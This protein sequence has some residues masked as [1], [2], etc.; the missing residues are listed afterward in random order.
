MNPR[1]A[2]LAVLVAALPAA[3]IRADDY[4]PAHDVRDV[5]W[6]AARLLART[7]RASGA[8][9]KAVQ[10][11]DVVVARDQALL[12][13]DS[14]K[15]HG[16]MT[17]VRSSDRWWDALDMLAPQAPGNCWAG[18][19]S[20]PLDDG[21]VQMRP[22][23]DLL[24]EHGVSPGLA[25]AAAAHNRDVRDAD[26]QVAACR[27]SMAQN[28]PDESIPPRGA[29]IRPLRAR[30]SG[31]D[32]T[33]AFSRNDASSAVQL[34]QMYA[35]APTRAEFVPNPAPAPGWGGPDAAC[36]FDISIGSTAP[37]TFSPGTTVDVWFPFVIDDQ[38]R[39]NLTFFS[40]GKPSGFI[41]GTVFDNT[42]HFAL[43]QFTLAPGK[44][45][46]AEIDGDAKRAR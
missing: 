42:L 3:P 46:M 26:S 4:G 31:Y 24:H 32:F 38:L 28:D 39:Y 21:L 36:F 41:F 11:S 22:A 30:T 37:V 45:L 20:Y 19:M 9:P 13:W 16:V 40:G 15:Q 27:V 7:V 14:G 25:A 17:L 1:I 12:S 18:S 23:T 35:R 43:P 8:D 5:R 2:L 33:I 6:N 29:T 44:P 34:M 10:I